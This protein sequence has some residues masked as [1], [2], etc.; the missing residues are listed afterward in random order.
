M[1]A[2]VAPA[3]GVAAAGAAAAPTAHTMLMSPFTKGCGPFVLD[4]KCI[5]LKDT[6][7]LVDML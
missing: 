4:I 2:K 1:T 5:G 3:R 6:N 7:L